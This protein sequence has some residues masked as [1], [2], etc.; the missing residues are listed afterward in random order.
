MTIPKIARYL[1]VLLTTFCIAY[2]ALARVTVDFDKTINFSKYKT[3]AWL[4][5][6]PAPNPLGQKRIQQAI[7]Q[8]L[9]EKGLTKADGAPD[10]YVVTHASSRKEQHINV[11]H[12]GY[13]GHRGR[14]GGYGGPG[15]TT[16]NVYDIPI[17]TLVV[18]ILDGGSK[19]LV[20]HAVAEETLSDD[21]QKNAKRIEKVT[22][23]MFKKF[24][25]KK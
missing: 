15:T 23:K 9:T 2:P 8:K 17:G 7:E 12:F 25:P 5:G 20:W 11:D 21:P 16:V 4:K 6:T 22:K 1:T 14:R 3:Y 24:P 10:L 19:E 13:G 18:D